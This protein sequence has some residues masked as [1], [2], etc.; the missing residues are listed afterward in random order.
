MCLQEESQECKE[1]FQVPI[2]IGT[3]LPT[4]CVGIPLPAECCSWIV[5]INFNGM[6]VFK[7]LSFPF[8]KKYSTNLCTVLI[9]VASMLLVTSLV[10]IIK[11]FESWL[12]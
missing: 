7:I 9:G 2:G 8:F 5:W 3:G 6:V 12:I 1:I 11:G 4:G 10:I